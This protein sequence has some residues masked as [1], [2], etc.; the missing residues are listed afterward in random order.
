MNENTLANFRCKQTSVKKFNGAFT[1]TTQQYHILT[2]VVQP[3][4]LSCV[5]R[6][7]RTYML[8]FPKIFR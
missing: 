5:D 1:T 2:K 6:K 4:H 7:V 3:V 8:D